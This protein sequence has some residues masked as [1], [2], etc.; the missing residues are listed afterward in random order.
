MAKKFSELKSKM[1]SEALQKAN[2]MTQQFLADLPLQELRQ[3]RHLSQENIAQIMH[4]KQASISKLEKRTDMYIKTLRSYIN[5]MGGQLDII[6]RFPEGD[7]RITQ[8][9]DL[10]EQKV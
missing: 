6:A 7:V 5:A 8:F 10:E 9:S 4:Q 3:A 1:S 2:N